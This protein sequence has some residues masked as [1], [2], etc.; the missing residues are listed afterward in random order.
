MGSYTFTWPYS[1]NEVFVTGTFDD[2]GKTV[3]LD[4]VGDVFEKEVP[5]PVTD[6]KVHYKSR[7]G[8]VSPSHVS[9]LSSP[10]KL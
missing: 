7:T 8:V 2:W 4:R 3:K 1:A 9:L 6:E 5:L 10:P